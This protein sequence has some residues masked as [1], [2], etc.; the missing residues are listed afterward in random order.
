[1]KAITISIINNKGGVGKTSSTAIFAELMAFL[2]LK[3]LCVDL[4]EQSNL[5]MLFQCYEEDNQK[6]I[7]GI[8]TPE[9][10]NISDLFK[11][12]FREKE[13][14]KQLIRKTAIENLYVIP[15]SKRH[16]NTLTYIAANETG[17]NN[18]ILR[19]ALAAIKEEFDFILI[20]NAPASNILTVNS[21]FASDYIITPVRAEGFSYKGLR[22]TIETVA[23]I[24]EEHDIENVNFLGTYI[25]QVET[26]TKI[27]KELR[28][29]YSEELGIK[30]LNTPIRKDI[31]VSEMETIFQS[32]LNYAPSTNAIFDYSH[33][34]LELN[35]LSKEKADMLRIAIGE[36]A[37]EAC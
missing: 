26:N 24:K 7:D 13:D 25:T 18:I 20:D 17:N 3:V 11:Y 14:V 16:K 27:F 19:K 8:E 5:S 28:E 6:V 37:S 32:L 31:K 30:F 36:T 35:I 23:Y 2:G 4:D 9:K 29:T 21:I 22:E 1:M 34:L 10:Y 33:L 12:R 15:S